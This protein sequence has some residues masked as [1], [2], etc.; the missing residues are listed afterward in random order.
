MRRGFKS[1]RNGFFE[2][3]LNG[4]STYIKGLG[5]RMSHMNIGLRVL[6]DERL[7]GKI[8]KYQF[9]TRKK[10][11]LVHLMLRKFNSVYKQKRLAVDNSQK[12]N[13]TK[14][15]IRPCNS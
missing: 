9:A 8:S 5:E 13:S 15:Y 6:K 4:I 2:A 10:E 3:Y 1:E 7:Y 11:Y 14:I 12:Q